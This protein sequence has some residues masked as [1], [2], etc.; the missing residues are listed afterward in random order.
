MM[1]RTGILCG[2]LVATG[3]TGSYILEPG[4]LLL[5]L[6]EEP[7]LFLMYDVIYVW[8][9]LFDNVVHF[10]KRWRRN[11]RNAPHPL[12]LFVESRV[13]RPIKMPD[14]SE[15]VIEEIFAHVLTGVVEEQID[16]VIHPDWRGELVG[17]FLE[18][19]KAR[20]ARRRPILAGEARFWSPYLRLANDRKLVMQQT[21][22]IATDDAGDARRWT[23][24]PSPGHLEHIEGADLIA[25]AQSTLRRRSR[26]LI[27]PLDEV[28]ASLVPDIYIDGG[29]VV[30]ANRAEIKTAADVLALRTSYASCFREMR[31][32]AAE[33]IRVTPAGDDVDPATAKRLWQRNSR[34]I[35]DV[36]LDHF[37][38]AR[39]VHRVMSSR[40]TA[41]AVDGTAFAATAATGIPLAIPG[42]GMVPDFV[43]NIPQRWGYKRAMSG[44]LERRLPVQTDWYFEWMDLERDLK[45]GR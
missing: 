19:E 20:Q 2:S 30:P 7:E 29:T 9:E 36:I 33:A 35:D 25:Q 41:L 11:G 23:N 8:E 28:L 13:I 21:L 39:R 22:D 43:S 32:V 16:D 40:L 44:T 24:H 10:L 6:R 42:L 37:P 3:T 18:L 27:E 45:Q 1:S 15:R 34:E 31:V 5:A 17:L 12:E 4:K 26:A 14:A 38:W